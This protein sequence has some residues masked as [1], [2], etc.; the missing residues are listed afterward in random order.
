MFSTREP[1]ESTSGL[2]LGLGLSFQIT[3]SG[4]TAAPLGFASSICLVWVI[5]RL[6][7]VL[8]R[9]SPSLLPFSSPAIPLL[10]PPPYLP[11]LHLLVL[12]EVRGEFPYVGFTAFAA[13]LT[14]MV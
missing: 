5:F 7:S 3:K 13:L 10:V 4:F 1:K 6:L 2:C 11:D 9:A 8:L 14:A 12:N